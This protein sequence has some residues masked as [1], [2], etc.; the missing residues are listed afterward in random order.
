MIPSLFIYYYSIRIL[1]STMTASFSP[2]LMASAGIQRYPCLTPLFGTSLRL[3]TP[4]PNGY[5]QLPNG[6]DQTKFSMR[7]Q[8]YAPLFSS[9]TASDISSLM[10]HQPFHAKELRSYASEFPKNQS[11][12]GDGRFNQLNMDGVLPTERFCPELPPDISSP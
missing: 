5:D 9:L 8:P 12:E 7:E 2:S 10:G 4:L 6:Y 11:V 3:D 1:L